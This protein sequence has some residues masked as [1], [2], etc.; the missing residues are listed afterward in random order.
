[1]GGTPRVVRRCGVFY[2]RMAAPKDLV[3]RVGHG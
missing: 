1:M 3:A 2:F